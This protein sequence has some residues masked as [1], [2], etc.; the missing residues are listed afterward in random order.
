MRGDLDLGDAMAATIRLCAHRAKPPEDRAVPL[1]WAR[2]LRKFFEAG[3]AEDALAGL[4]L[5]TDAGMLDAAAWLSVAGLLHGR[6]N[7]AEAW[8]V[9]EEAAARLP[10][11]AEV[12]VVAGLLRLD[13]GLMADAEE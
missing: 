4:R 5:A 6:G 13:C 7:E 8:L 1:A 3:R 9:V 10:A 11:S 12:W 2:A